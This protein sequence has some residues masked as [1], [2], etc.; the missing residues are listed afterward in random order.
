MILSH[1][2]RMA[3]P[4]H[5]RLPPR[6]LEVLK[7]FGEGWTGKEIATRLGITQATVSTYR[8]MIR[9]VAELRSGHEIV[10]YCWT[11]GLVS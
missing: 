3:L 9:D 8:A 1:A 10:R 4:P 5:E 11:R 7:L 6:G 2:A